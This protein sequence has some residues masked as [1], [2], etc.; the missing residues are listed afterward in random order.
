VG[1]L[2]LY[3]VVAQFAEIHN[4]QRFSD[5]LVP[6]TARAAFVRVLRLVFLIP[7]TVGEWSI[8]QWISLLGVILPLVVAWLLWME[9][10]GR[11]R[12]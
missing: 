5:C 6:V 4:Q 7:I 3:V 2:A 10:H 9:N 11:K 1:R 12:H 8:P